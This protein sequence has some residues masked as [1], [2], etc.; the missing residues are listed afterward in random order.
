MYTVSLTASNIRTIR[1]YNKSNNYVDSPV[2]CNDYRCNSLF[3]NPEDST[4]TLYDDKSYT[5]KVDW[6]TV[7]ITRKNEITPDHFY[8]KKSE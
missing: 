1:K 8:S 4:G 3:M 5:S 6:G 7:R 2:H